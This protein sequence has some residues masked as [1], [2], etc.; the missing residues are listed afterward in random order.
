MSLVVD[1]VAIPGVLAAG[2]FAYRGDG[3][4]YQG[5]LDSEQARMASIMCR[6]NSLAIHMQAGIVSS[7]VEKSGFSPPRGWVVQG[8]H[9]TV[10]VLGNHFCFLEQTST[11]LN[12]V[13]AL[14]RQQAPLPPVSLR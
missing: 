6:A 3:F 1:L 4:T 8:N 9:F 14:M 7:L 12:Q 10:C 5:L 13:L 11:S 2:E